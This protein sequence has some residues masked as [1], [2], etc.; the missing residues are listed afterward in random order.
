LSRSDYDPRAYWSERL[1][2]DFSLRGTGHIAYSERY[3]RWL[4]RAKRTAL[5]RALAEVG[6]PAKAFDIGSGTGWVIRELTEFG[7]SVEGSDLTLVAVER[8]RRSFPAIEFHQLAIGDDRIPRPDASFDLVTALDVLYHVPDDGDWA[9]GIREVARILRPG[10]SLVASDG[11][12]DHDERPAAH[13]RFRSRERWEREASRAGMKVGTVIPLYR[14]LSRS[15][16]ESRLARL[17]DR[18]RGPIEYGLERLR[19]GRPHMRCAVL[20]RLD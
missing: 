8:L 7:D 12:G 6:H 16:S 9:A 4:Y 20:T 5:R 2:E 17:P 13:V 18:L 3:N 11:L 19:I 10:G 1:E 15:P 14:W